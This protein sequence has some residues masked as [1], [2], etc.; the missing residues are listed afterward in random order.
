MLKS[1]LAVLLGFALAQEP[2]R[3]QEPGNP[4]S[5]EINTIIVT[6]RLS[7]AA[8]EQLQEQVQTALHV[9]P[10]FYDAHVTVTVE[11]GVVYL[12]GMVYDAADLQAARRIAK[13]IAGSGRVVDE[14]EINDFNAFD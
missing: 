12:S 2:L 4:D 3:V 10:Y 13:K 14:L 9:D 11:D 7:H 5:R 6:G 8:D 1:T